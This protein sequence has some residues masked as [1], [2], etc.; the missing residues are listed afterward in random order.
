MPGTPCSSRPS[1]SSSTTTGE[2]AGGA[3]PLALLPSQWRTRPPSAW[4]CCVL[5]PSSTCSL[6]GPFLVPPPAPEARGPA[7]ELPVTA[8]PR[9]GAPPPEHPTACGLLMGPY[10]RMAVCL[11]PCVSLLA[12]QRRTAALSPRIFQELSEM[13][14]C[15]GEA[16]R[17]GQARR[18]SQRL[19]FLV[20]VQL[21]SRA[22]C[23]RP[24]VGCR[25]LGFL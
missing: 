12:L 19:C 14:V 11:V 5:S 25:V 1:A 16:Q 8:L 7:S 15:V 22:S 3:L 4:A 6:R 2:A 20:S 24:H 18:D 17:W 21:C 13:A 10:R 23:P 9:A